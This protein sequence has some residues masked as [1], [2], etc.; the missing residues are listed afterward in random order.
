MG[1]TDRI[2]ISLEPRHASNIYDGAKRVEFR[3]RQMHVSPGTEVYIYEKMPVGAITG[4]AI[5]KEVNIGTPTQLWRRYGPVSGLEKAEFFS[6]FA[7]IEFGCAIVLENAQPLRSAIG[8]S[9]LRAKLS[10]FHPPQFYLR[11]SD[12]HG[13]L[14]ILRSSSWVT[15]RSALKAA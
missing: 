15:T 11:L 13:L 2:L 5:V 1:N 9:S 8:L 12:N 4:R 14:R 7:G 3:R 6:Y 10:A